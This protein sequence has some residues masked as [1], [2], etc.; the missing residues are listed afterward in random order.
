MPRGV[1]RALDGDQQVAISIRELDRIWHLIDQHR[2][3][4]RRRFIVQAHPEFWRAM[5]DYGERWGS[6]FIALQDWEDEKAGRET[7]SEWLDRELSKPTD[8]SPSSA[9]AGGDDDEWDFQPDEHT[10]ADHMEGIAEYVAGKADDEPFFSRATGAWDWLTKTVGLDVRSIEKKWR[11]FPVLIIPEQI[12]NKHGLD[13]PNSLF[14]YLEN[15]RLAY[16]T[17][18]NLAAIAMCRAATEILIRRHYNADPDTKLGLLINQTQK[19]REFNWLKQEN[20]SGK[21]E[22]ANNILHFKRD[23]IHNVD[24]STALVREWV[25]SLQLMIAR[26]PHSRKDMANA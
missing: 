13:D 15:V 23:D 14:S 19:K 21:V 24:R 3:Y 6:S 5:K 26:A 8:D 4:A 18:A 17:G 2:R 9:G 20:I 7:L 1:K 22:E 25:K 12:S 16:L 11:E 10:A